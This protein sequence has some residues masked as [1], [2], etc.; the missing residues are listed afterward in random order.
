MIGFYGIIQIFNLSVFN[1]FRAGTV[2]SL[3][4]G[5]LRWCAWFNKIK[6]YAMLFR[7]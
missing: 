4:K 3:N 1:Q 2:K 6:L 7:S 5:I